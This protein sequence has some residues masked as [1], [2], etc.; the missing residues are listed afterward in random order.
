VAS[1]GQQNGSAGPIFRAAGEDEG[2]EG[3]HAL[4]RLSREGGNPWWLWDTAGLYDAG[5]GG[6]D[7]RTPVR[8][9]L[10]ASSFVPHRSAA[11]QSKVAQFI[12]AKGLRGKLYMAEEG[13]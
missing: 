3:Y 4:Y 13:W 5:G 7:R 8:L 2:G 10:G 1:A 11:L 6:M 9:F 12:V